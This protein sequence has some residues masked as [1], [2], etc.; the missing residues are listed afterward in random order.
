MI[1]PALKNPKQEKMK[2]VN[3]GYWTTYSTIS[4]LSLVFE[5]KTFRTNVLPL[6]FRFRF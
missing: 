4:V 2:S 6:T 3:K 1:G 5:P